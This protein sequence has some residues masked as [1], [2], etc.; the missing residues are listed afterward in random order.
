MMNVIA[1]FEPY[2]CLSRVC[3][4][5]PNFFSPFTG[6]TS[7]RSTN[8]NSMTVAVQSATGSCLML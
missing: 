4:I 6:E 7:P 1:Q 3:S 2:K 5:F 8:S